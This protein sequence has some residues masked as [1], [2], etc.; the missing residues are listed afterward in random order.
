MKIS[1]DPEKS[2][3]PG[4]KAVYRLIDAEGEGVVY[5]MISQKMHSSYC[6]RLP[7]NIPGCVRLLL[8]IMQ[9]RVILDLYMMFASVFN[10][11]NYLKT[12]WLCY[13]LAIFK[14]FF[15]TI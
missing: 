15:W 8:I 10:V 9:F 6:R 1:E 4:R 7:F 12:E 3:V 2:T 13:P 14:M 11:Q 5:T